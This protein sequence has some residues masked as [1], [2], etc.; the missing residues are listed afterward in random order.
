MN[1]E[2]RKVFPNIALSKKW[3]ESAVLGET[4]KEHL[5]NSRESEH[6]SKDWVSQ[7]KVWKYLEKNFRRMFGLCN[8][9]NLSTYIDSLIGTVKQFSFSVQIE[10]EYGETSGSVSVSVP[11]EVFD[12]PTGENL[13][14][15][16]A[17]VAEGESRMLKQEAKEIQKRLARFRA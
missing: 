15:W 4:L 12:N 16:A 13:N 14:K 7:S 1:T 3:S 9:S 8:E 6:V 10:N 5:G 11:Y 17:Q 2:K